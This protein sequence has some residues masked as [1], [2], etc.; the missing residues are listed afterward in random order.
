MSAPS[1]DHRPDTRYATTPPWD[2]DRPQPV[3]LALAE[4]GALTGRVLDAGCGTGEHALLA[5]RLGL[6]ATGVDLSAEA[7]AGAAAKARERG[8]TARF[9]EYDAGRLGELGETFDTVLDCGLF[10]LFTGAA[11]QRY[12][13]ALAAVIPSGGRF[14]MLGFSDAQPGSWGPHRLSRAEIDAA[15]ADG[16][17]VD[18]LEA[19]TLEIAVGAGAAAA[20]FVQLTRR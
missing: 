12:V 3:F 19:A 9:L 6:D 11:R 16:W 10:H 2:I 13:R 15:F 7:L 1:P 4:S 17:Q 8:L 18:A 20:W 14:F 5:A